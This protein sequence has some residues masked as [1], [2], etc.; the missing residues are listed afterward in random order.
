M[1]EV[2]VQGLPVA[3]ED[4]LIAAQDQQ[5]ME[6]GLLA[7]HGADIGLDGPGGNAGFLRRAVS[8]RFLFGIHG[9]ITNLPMNVPPL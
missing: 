5:R 6:R 3:L 8:E 2:F 7:G 1:A 9:F 4:Q